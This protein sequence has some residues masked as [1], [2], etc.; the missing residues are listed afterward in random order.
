MRKTIMKRIIAFLLIFALAIAA[1][2][3]VFAEPNTTDQSVQEY[4]TEKEIKLNFVGE[5]FFTTLLDASINLSSNV[6]LTALGK[7]GEA[8]DW[9]GLEYLND[10]LGWIT[11]SGCTDDTL[12][13]ILKLCQEI[14]KDVKQLD[15]DL[16]FM[17][18]QLQASIHDLKQYEVTQK[19]VES[20]AEIN[21]IYNEYHSIIE[22]YSK[23]VNSVSDYAKASKLFLHNPNKTNKSARDEA[24]DK[25][26]TNEKRFYESLPAQDKIT[27]D[28]NGIAKITCNFY[29]SDK[30]DE[31]TKNK[32][33]GYTHARKAHDVCSEKLPFENQKYDFMYYSIND[34]TKT[35]MAMSQV[36][37]LK[38][39]HEMAVE[40]KDIKI[41]SDKAEE[42]INRCLNAVN[43]VCGQYDINGYVR[44]YDFE[45]TKDMNYK[46]SAEHTLEVVDQNR[47]KYYDK[48]PTEAKKSHMKADFYRVQVDNDTYLI[49]K[50]YGYTLGDMT[51]AYNSWDDNVRTLPVN[52]FV[53]SQDWFNNQSTADGAYKMID[54]ASM[55]ES[56][57]RSTAY[58]DYSPQFAK[59]LASQGLR[60]IPKITSNDFIAVDNI[61]SCKKGIVF[62]TNL[63]ETAYWF[64]GEMQRDFYKDSVIEQRFDDQKTNRMMFIYKKVGAEKYPVSARAENH[65][66]QKYNEKYGTVEIADTSGTAIKGNFPSGSLIKIKVTE[67]KDGELDR[68]VIKSKSGKVLDELA[69]TDTF[70]IAKNKDGT[71]TFTY[72]MPYQ[73]AI[74]EACF[75]EGSR[76]GSGTVDDPYIIN[77]FEDFDFYVKKARTQD[78]SRAC[79]ELN[80][81]IDLP[82][83]YGYNAEKKSLLCDKEYSGIFDGKS[84]SIS[85]C[86][87]TLFKTVDQGGQILDAVFEYSKPITS[88]NTVV[89]ENKG[90]IDGI[91][92]AATGYDQMKNIEQ[93]AS[94][95]EKNS[96]NIINSSSNLETNKLNSYCLVYDN[97][98][99]TIKN[100]YTYKEKTKIRSG[101]IIAGIAYKS[102]EKSKIINSFT[103]TNALTA[104]GKDPER[105]SKN[106]YYLRDGV[107]ESWGTGLDKEEMNN[108]NVLLDMLNKYAKTNDSLRR[109]ERNPDVNGGFPYFSHK[110]NLHSLSISETGKGNIELLNTDGHVAVKSQPGNEITIKATADTGNRLTD[111]SIIDSNGKVIK[112]FI[113]DV[114]NSKSVSEKF[115]MPDSDVIVK[116]VFTNK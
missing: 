72:P 7:A 19:Y 46:S 115:S 28:I 101:K 87:T 26:G 23:Y 31:T 25:A 112:T 92:V 91:N 16:K 60:D 8:T 79:Y 32:A 39:D 20:E 70:N 17:D 59:Y 66:D 10:A 4:N 37:R 76:G 5:W 96:G 36:A 107:T 95:V 65:T 9:S 116:A 104:N 102:D 51:Y 68:V 45:T 54:N 22:K 82:D 11:G 30:A 52:Y 108:S 90:L 74:I 97:S 61:K 111:L 14:S 35:F 81:N 94:I 57:I 33:S 49:Q 29:P 47:K 69:T 83:G 85:N 99:G 84:Y 106:S 113:I 64:T 50:D 42:N 80:G 109:W 48:Y 40:N 71:Y 27:S 67:K 100:C 3:A 62:D 86:G 105:N 89:Y 77:D 78:M 55:I 63:W 1:P 24:K 58:I 41:E 93:N 38:F 13:Q 56:L 44:D 6:V 43:D 103:N 21:G 12:N 15:K 88:I 75:Q 53:R 98:G 73:D 18:D 2:A 110:I 114:K 34:C